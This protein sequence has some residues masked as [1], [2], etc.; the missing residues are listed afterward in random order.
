MLPRHSNAVIRRNHTEA[1]SRGWLAILMLCVAAWA[2]SSGGSSTGPNVGAS[3][4]SQGGKG[5]ASG[6]GG[7]AGSEA[8]GGAG[9]AAAGAS[10]ET[11]EGGSSAGGDGGDGGDGGAL[12]GSAGTAGTAGTAGNSE[13]A[14]TGGTGAAGPLPDPTFTCDEGFEN[15]APGWTVEGGQWAFG[16]G[17]VN[18]PAPLVGNKLAGTVLG[19]RY[20]ANADARLISPAIVVPAASHYPRFRYAYWYDLGTGDYAQLQVRVDGGA[21]QNVAAGRLEQSSR[22]W[23]QRVLDLRPYVGKTVQIGFRLVTDDNATSASTGFGWYLDN[24]SCRSGAAVLHAPEGFEE[25][26]RGDWSVEGGQWA[27]GR[28]NVNELAPLVG[29][30]L[31]GTVLG[32]RYGSNV[33]ARLISP[34]IIVPAAEDKPRFKYS[35]FYDFGDGDYGQLEIRVNGSLWQ[36]VNAG[37]LDQSSMGWSQRVVDLRPY[38]GKVVE[39]AFRIVTDTSAIQASTSGMGYYVDEVSL[40][41]GA[42]V[43]KNNEGFEGEDH[44]D[45][46]VE[47]GQWAFGRGN[48]N[49]LAP[50][51]G[52]KL[53]GTVLSARYGSN[54]DARLISPEIT[55]PAAA[56]KPRFKYSYYYDFGDGDYGQLEIRESGGAWQALNAGKL[57][58]SSM[59]WSQRVVDLRDYAGKV[60]QLAFRIVTNTNTNQAFT[61]GYGYYIDEFSLETGAWVFNNNEGFE[62]T[63]HSDWSVEG[64]QWAF[65]R[66]NVNELAPL[67]G[68]KLAGTVLGARYGSNVDARLISPEIT[69]PNA[70]L[71]PRFKFAYFYDFG[72]GDYGQLEIRESGGAWQPVTG[73]KLDQEGND[74]SQR[75][76]DLRP[77]AGKVVQVAF[78]IVTD[79]STTQAASSGYGYYI[80]QFV[81]ETGPWLFTNNE[82][83]E[84]IDHADWSVEGGQWAFGRGNV[85]EPTPHTDLKLA[86]TV[87]GGRYGSNVDARLIS[88]EFVVP[89][90]ASM[91][92]YDWY[93]FGTGDQGQL[94]IRVSG[95]SWQNVVGGSYSAANKV[96]TLRSLDLKAY[97]GSTVQVG[98]RITTDLST[99]SSATS[100]FGWYV[101]DVAVSG[102]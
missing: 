76:L 54:V 33:D 63:D 24:I 21:W 67:A 64:G 51:V 70:A 29:T 72:D 50:L 81:L 48:V 16:T 36:P 12:T 94:Q 30:K 5:A 87:L 46:S 49:E 14:G 60:V 41:T 100:G 61:S 19:A 84:G 91:T 8:P 17:N 93:D 25:P 53:A 32:D 27:F 62:G 40:E 42:W 37:R 98:F 74:W 75:V 102:L 55:V 85:N 20:G 43:F 92:Y 96:W 88:P 1:S 6:F 34:E 7:R 47:G 39:L 83:F 65:G 71:N 23:S 57:D 95:G 52:D 26:D 66:G 77:Y 9:D 89:A 44:S 11:G 59:G 10:G 58:Q 90:N 31:A 99:S 56:E 38:A 45:W 4:A 28:G 3:G 78:R 15:G 101:D 13:T 2:C 79:T 80:D 68:D 97:S 22:S 86:G 35:Y 69:V 73:G 82:S 18:E